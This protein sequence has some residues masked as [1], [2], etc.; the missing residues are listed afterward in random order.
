LRVVI[1]VATRNTRVRFKIILTTAV[2]TEGDR[3][4]C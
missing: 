3:E 4:E 2:H 1:S